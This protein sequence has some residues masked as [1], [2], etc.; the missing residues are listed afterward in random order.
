MLK[1]VSS[2][3]T[4]GALPPEPLPKASL[5][6]LGLGGVPRIMPLARNPTGGTPD[7]AAQKAR[8]WPIQ[9]P[10]MQ[11][12]AQRRAKADAVEPNLAVDD[13]DA[14]LLQPCAIRP[15]PH[16]LRCNRRCA[17]N[18]GSPPPSI[19]QVVAHIE[20]KSICPDRS[21][22]Q[23]EKPRPGSPGEAEGRRPRR[24]TGTAYSFRDCPAL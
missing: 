20:A 10:T 16:H 7:S 21:A 1:R 19:G 24:I 3:P 12:I 6:N 8:P 9:R 5:W 11:Y 17:Q 22:R 15:T 18:V 4:E 13:N 14:G 2:I 23:L